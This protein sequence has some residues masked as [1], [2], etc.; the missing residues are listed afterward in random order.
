MATVAAQLHTP[1][2][3]A[4]ARQGSNEPSCR[5]TVR[6]LASSCRARE[7]RRLL[8]APA[9]TRAKRTDPEQRFQRCLRGNASGVV[10]IVDTRKDFR[11]YLSTAW[12]C[13]VY[14]L[15]LLNLA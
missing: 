1:R 8:R 9:A 10:I 7:P 12:S 11:T 13:V 14:Y 4:R 3:L 2:S 6:A 5:A 15:M